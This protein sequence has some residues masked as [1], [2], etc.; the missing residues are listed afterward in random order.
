M[1]SNFSLLSLFTGDLMTLFVSVVLVVFSV[2]SWTVIV[3]KVRLWHGQKRNPV[4]MKPDENLD[5]HKQ[6][7]SARNG[8]YGY[9]CI[10]L[11]ILTT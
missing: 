3:E 11:Y 6:M 1:E 5:I 7:K 2:L 4:K 10:Y 8:M 9:M